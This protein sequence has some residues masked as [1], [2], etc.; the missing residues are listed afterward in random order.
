MPKIIAN[1]KIQKLFY[2]KKR[3]IKKNLLFR[4]ESDKIK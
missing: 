3:N 2:E 1:Y 4:A